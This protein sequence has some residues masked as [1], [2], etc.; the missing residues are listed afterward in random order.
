MS[1]I[2]YIP[3]EIDGVNDFSRT[4]RKLVAD[5]VKRGVFNDDKTES[6]E[7]TLVEY[8]QRLNALEQGGSDPIGVDSILTSGISFTVLVDFNG[9]VLVTGVT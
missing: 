2:K 6:V 4:E 1:E 5:D 9:N 8:D 7:E 3:A